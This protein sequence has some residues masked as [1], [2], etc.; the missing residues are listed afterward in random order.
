VWAGK[1]PIVPLYWCD[2][3]GWAST[4]FRVDAV[5]THHA[6]C[7]DCAGTLRLTYHIATAPPADLGDLRLVLGPDRPG[8]GL[9]DPQHDRSA[10]G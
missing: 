8:P 9:F 10:S 4:A 3:C 1:T 5:R 2:G 7:P 6:D